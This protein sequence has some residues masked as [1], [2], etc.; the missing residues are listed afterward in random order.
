MNF[1]TYFFLNFKRA[2]KILPEILAITVATAFFI[3][4]I[5]LFMFKQNSESEDTKKINVAFV[6]DITDTY[7]DVGIYALQNMDTSRFSINFINTTE[8]EAEKALKSG[9]LSGYLRIPDGFVYSIVNGENIPITYVSLNSPSGFTSIIMREI[10]DVAS[11]LVIDSQSA[12]FSAQNFAQ[13]YAEDKNIYEVANEISLKYITNILSRNEAYSIETAD[14]DGISVGAYYICGFI[15][16]FLLLWGI[17]SNK[18]LSKS[19]YWLQRSLASRG[20]GVIYQAAG[21]YFAFF[22]VTMITALLFSFIVGIGVTY[23]DFGIEEISASTTIDCMLFVI[24]L[25]PVILMITLMQFMIYELISSKAGIVIFQFILAVFL[26]YISGYF[27]PSSFF[28]ES[29]N[30]LSSF[31]PSGIGFS[32]AKEC[33]GNGLEIKSFLGAFAYI[34]LFSVIIVI[35]RKKRLEGDR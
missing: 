21:E 28:P 14:N 15:L 23:V 24:K 7:L 2:L 34:S 3:L 5:G 25:V 8:E 19:S 33:I 22:A 17:S 12:I 10:T 27:Y 18:I 4:I 20:K 6:G 35:A 13:K 31:L 11:D 9:E 26:G 16:F 29:V 30:L 32:Y 1:K